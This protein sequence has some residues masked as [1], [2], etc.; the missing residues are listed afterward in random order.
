[1]LILT[2]QELLGNNNR[3]FE[4]DVMV[5]FNEGWDKER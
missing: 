1:M 2:K 4:V 3:N 5:C